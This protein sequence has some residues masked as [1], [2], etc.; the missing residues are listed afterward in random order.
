MGHSHSGHL[1]KITLGGLV[2]TLG[3]I[4]G[5]IGTSPLYV[6]KE[7][8]GDT[9]INA[10]LVKGAVSAIFWTLTLQTTFK[11]VILTL[12]ADNK[13]EGGIFSLYTL[14]K[15]SKYKWLIVPAIV[16]GCALLADGIIT[17][18]ISVA[19]AI[20]GLRLL[21]PQINTVPIVI[22]FIVGLFVIQRFGSKWVGRFFG[23]MMFIWFSMLGV[24][25]ISNIGCNFHI[26][27]GLNPY[28]TYKLLHD[29]PAGILILSSVFL[30]TTGAEALYSD[31][32]HCGKANI[33]VSWIFVK[34]M[35]VLNYFGQGAWLMAHEGKT[36]N[37]SNPFFDIMPAW[38]ILPG[39]IIAT[40]AT[41]IASQ[42]LISGS[43]TLINEA[44]RLNLWPKVK[45]KYPSDLKGQ[46]YIPSINWLLMFGCI[47][48]VL[49]FRESSNM[50]AAYG[51]AIVLC[52]LMTT[53]LLNFYM[54]LKR[55]NIIFIVTVIAIYAIVEL[56]FLYANLSKFKNGGWITLLIAGTLM[57]IMAIWIL[58][59]KISKRYTDEVPLD[60]YKRFLIDLSRDESIPKYAT[61]LVYLTSV[62]DPK[63]IE[64]KIIHSILQRRP[65]KADI[66]WFVHV[67][68]MD[69]PY[70][71]DYLVNHIAEDDIIRVDF[72]LGFRVAPKINLMFRKVVEDLVQNKEV[73]ITSR[74]ESLQ[75][76][77]VSGDFKFVIV[78]KYLS[79][80]NDL[81][82]FEKIILE[83][84]YFL[85]HLSLSE[86]RAF[87]LDNSSIKVEK[88]PM[89]FKTSGVINNLKRLK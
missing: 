11:Y 12:R 34:V 83:A 1:N 36:L 3:I 59:K 25:G 61:H 48:V 46:L 60:D 16:G 19:S 10:E 50:G 47:G 73:D 89:I 57:I 67:D 86:A 17:P 54:H 33:R 29:H 44:M 9:P 72:R 39:I 51:L 7:I 6:L 13:G 21:Y 45:V 14:V 30:C 70:R 23:P 2:V 78:E 55:Y 66:Y 37:G 81:P 24:L 77:N 84:Y 85:K 69:E 20:E 63:M 28:Y 4:Y 64:Q 58:A 71:M 88:F 8:V 42:A 75:R 15:R 79:Y 35:L 43:F 68:V 56:A 76:N 5:D 74:Y 49:Y 26:I 32:G 82:I 80:D 52:M 40:S 65:K 31:L 38:F 18:P 53:T 41:I 27:E 62:N 87:G 22:G